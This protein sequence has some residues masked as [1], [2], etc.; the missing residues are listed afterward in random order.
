MQNLI[1]V[2]VCLG[3]GGFHRKEDHVEAALQELEHK[4]TEAVNLDKKAK[5]RVASAKKRKDSY[6]FANTVQLLGECCHLVV[7]E[8]RHCL[9]LPPS[10][11][12]GKALLGAAT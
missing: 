9:V 3:W 12:R 11:V 6:D 5:S 7:W 8:K 1:P 2:I 10:G 4:D